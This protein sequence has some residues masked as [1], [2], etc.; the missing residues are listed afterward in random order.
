M[1][2]K[3]QIHNYDGYEFIL[4]MVTSED[5][6]YENQKGILVNKGWLPHERK[7]L[8]NRRG[9]EDSFT[10]RTVVGIVT[11]GEPFVNKSLFRKGNVFDE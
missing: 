1:Y 10:R 3:H 7:D 11:K 2:I 8:A 9:F 6:N 5:E 4:P